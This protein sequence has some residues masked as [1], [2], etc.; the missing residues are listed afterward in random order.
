ME[1]NSGKWGNPNGPAKENVR[2]IVAEALI[3][4]ITNMNSDTED[5][6]GMEDE[7]RA[8]CPPLIILGI[9]LSFL[10]LLQP[11]LSLECMLLFSYPFRTFPL[12]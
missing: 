1:P 12:S 8:S 2:R 6:E 9:Y 3:E 7:R 5:M 10:K 11:F 4:R